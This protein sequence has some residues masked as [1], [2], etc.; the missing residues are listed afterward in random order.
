MKTWLIAFVDGAAVE[1]CCVGLEQELAKMSAT[2]ISQAG[3]VCRE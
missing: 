1:F 3:R 2:K